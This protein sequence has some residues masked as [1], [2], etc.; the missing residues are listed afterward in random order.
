MCVCVCVCACAIYCWGQR[1]S[2]IERQNLCTICFGLLIVQNIF[3][4]CG[5]FVR[6]CTLQT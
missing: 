6:S 1:A 3:M 4:M 2:G 5:H